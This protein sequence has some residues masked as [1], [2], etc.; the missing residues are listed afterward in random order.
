MHLSVAFMS[1]DPK[2]TKRKVCHH[3]ILRF[4][5][6]LVKN[7]LVKTLMKLT[8]DW[9]N[10]LSSKYDLKTFY[11]YHLDV[12]FSHFFLPKKLDWALIFYAL[13]LRPCKRHTVLLFCVYRNTNHD[14]FRSYRNHIKLIRSFITAKFFGKLN[15]K[16]N[17]LNVLSLKM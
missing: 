14:Q 4:W 12:D 5:N 9:N 7:L 8:L 2:S 1:V 15:K 6:L 11:S 10:T 3:C 13:I 17:K 16:I